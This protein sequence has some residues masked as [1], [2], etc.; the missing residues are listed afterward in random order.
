MK[1][2]ILRSSP[3][4][5]S[6]KSFKILGFSVHAIEHCHY[7]EKNLQ[8]KIKLLIPI[9]NIFQFCIKSLSIQC[10][11]L[12]IMSIASQKSEGKKNNKI[13]DELT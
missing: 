6:L 1:N 2:C 3:I 5:V 10:I 12:S 4:I 11:E 8:L 13:V 9:V 7:R